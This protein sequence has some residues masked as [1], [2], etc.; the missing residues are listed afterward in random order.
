MNDKRRRPAEVHD[1]DGSVRLRDGARQ[2]F[3]C[4]RESF[5]AFRSEASGFRIIR[6]P[7]VV[8]QAI[9]QFL[10][11]MDAGAANIEAVCGFC[12]EPGSQRFREK[13]GVNSD[14]AQWLAQIVAGRVIEFGEL[15]IRE[16]QF[17]IHAGE[18]ALGAL[19]FGHVH[20]DGQASAKRAGIQQRNG[21][22]Q[23]STA[24]FVREAEL[25]FL[26]PDRGPG[27]ARSLHRQISG[28]EGHPIRVEW[29]RRR[30]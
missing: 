20:G 10:H 17:A 25:D 3:A 27:S 24:A 8:L 1:F 19:N 6:Q 21:I 18:F 7:S 5:P 2:I 11:A 12:I 23:K 22:D 30:R 26:V 13:L 15:L 28:C 14:L 29:C 4:R 16:K 9:K